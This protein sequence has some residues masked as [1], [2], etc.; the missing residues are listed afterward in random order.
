MLLFKWHAPLV[1]GNLVAAGLFEKALLARLLEVMPPL[2]H[3]EL[4][5]AGGNQGDDATRSSVSMLTE[6]RMFRLWPRVW[7]KRYSVHFS[8]RNALFWQSYFVLL[9]RV[10]SGRVCEALQHC[11]EVLCAQPLAE[12][13]FHVAFIELAAGSLR[14]L[15]KPGEPDV[16]LRRQAWA[17]LHPFLS[18][19]LQQASKERL[20]EWCDAVRF[21]VRGTSC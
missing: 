6:P 21:I 12:A 2:H 15:R 11:G 17:V 4:L 18:S 14:S 8:L 9:A 16:A 1:D 13:E 20:K 7:T 19:E 3:G 5:N 10:D